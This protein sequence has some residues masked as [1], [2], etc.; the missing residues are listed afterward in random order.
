[1]CRL[2]LAAA[3]LTLLSGCALAPLPPV[4]GSGDYLKVE[5]LAPLAPEV[6]ESSGLAAH[7][8]QLWTLNDSANGPYLYAINEGQVAVGCACRGRPISTGSR[9]RR[10][11]AICM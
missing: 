6:A 9:W 8:G 5:T 11:N 2:A 3:L 7:K 1:M 10:M 4:S